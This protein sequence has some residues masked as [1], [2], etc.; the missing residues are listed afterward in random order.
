MVQSSRRSTRARARTASRLL[1]HAN[2]STLYARART[3]RLRQG[4]GW[5]RLR[6]TKV[7]P[8][9]RRGYGEGLADNQH[10]AMGSEFADQ[11]ARAR[12]GWGWFG[13]SGRGDYG[14][15]AC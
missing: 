9:Y 2:V 7:L 3:A 12:E 5:C 11:Y 13:V 1:K 8:K 15:G 4:F 10:R 14:V 6:R